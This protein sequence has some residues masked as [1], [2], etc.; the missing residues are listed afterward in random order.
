[1]QSAPATGSEFSFE[2]TLPISAPSQHSSPAP[3]PFQAPALS[4]RILVVEDNRVNQRVIELLLE[5][6]GLTPVVVADGAAAVEVAV[7]EKWSAVLMDCQMPGMD[8]FEAT[9]QIRRR[10]AGQPL[11]IIALTANAMAGDRDAC[12]AAGMDDFI[13]KPIRQEELRACL[14]RWLVPAAT[15][16]GIGGEP[17]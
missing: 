3:P 8:G 9:R 1:M 17:V 5:K 14:E 6:L 7:F 11:P 4:G 2:L 15:S 10:L 13:P 16:T 12:V